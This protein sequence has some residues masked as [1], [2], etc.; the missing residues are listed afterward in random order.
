MLNTIAII[1]FSSLVSWNWGGTSPQFQIKD[2]SCVSE[3][4]IARIHLIQKQD[5][6]LEIEGTFYNSSDME[7]N[8]DY[9]LLVIKSGQSSSS[10]N[11]SGSFKVKSKMQVVLS[12]ITV[13]L[14]KDD[15]YKIKLEVFRNNQ[16][17]ADDNASFYGDKITQN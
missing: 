2:I 17:I 14:N 13:N 5:K 6:M 4:F 1:L 12:K 3:N 8:V 7:I 9:K 16:L 10:S 15:F 11:Q